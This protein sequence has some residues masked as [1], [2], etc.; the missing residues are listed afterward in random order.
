MD[1]L[2]VSPIDRLKYRGIHWLLEKLY[3]RPAGVLIAE[4]AIPAS[5]QAMDM[6]FENRPLAA[7]LPYEVFTDDGLFKTV[8]GT[9]RQNS[10]TIFSFGFALNIPH[11]LQV[12][13]ARALAQGIEDALPEQYTL[14]VMNA[15]LPGDED[16][17]S[18][19]VCLTAPDNAP[20]EDVLKLRE[21]YENL[22]ADFEIS[23]DRF[24]PDAIMG[25]IGQAFDTVPA[26]AYDD[27]QIIAS[28][29]SFAGVKITLEN[30]QLRTEDG[31]IFR[32]LYLYSPRC[33]GLK[34]TIPLLGI[35]PAIINELHFITQYAGR[36]TESGFVGQFVFAELTEPG[37]PSKAPSVF[38]GAGWLMERDVY[39]AH[40]SLLSLFPMAIS[41]TMAGQMVRLKRWRAF[42]ANHVR[43]ILPL[44]FQA[45]MQ[46]A[47]A[48]G[49][50]VAF[51]RDATYG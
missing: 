29:C 3:E 50:V 8:N 17:Y 31:N 23:A 16:R 20:R 27:H 24:T 45:N 1:G 48:S 15:R 30:V 51:K 7:F 2:A 19:F 38:S 26:A 5:I 49:A 44:P 18:A 33:Y 43:A 9:K 40:L 34:G 28:Q 6:L 13:Q 42:S 11:R 4:G 14:Q 47:D 46:A 39:N 41:A 25:F 10:Q 32:E 35:F 12:A 21:T 36:R 37:K 22:F